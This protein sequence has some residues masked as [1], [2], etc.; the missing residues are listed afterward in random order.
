[1]LKS[2]K[3]LFLRAIII[4]MALLELPLSAIAADGL[5]LAYN[6]HAMDPYRAYRPVLPDVFEP[7]L[8]QPDRV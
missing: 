2:L 1:M 8:R 5:G 4:G 3:K 7:L 6:P